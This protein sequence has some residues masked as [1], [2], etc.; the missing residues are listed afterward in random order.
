[1]SKDKQ[2][3]A[4]LRYKSPPIPEQ[5]LEL[6]YNLYHKGTEL[7]TIVRIINSRLDRAAL[8]AGVP[9]LSICDLYAIL[10]IGITTGG[11]ATDN[12]KI[13]TL[14]QRSKHLTHELRIA[15]F[16]ALYRGWKSG[17]TITNIIADDKLYPGTDVAK[18]RAI[19]S[20][21]LRIS[22][23]QEK[24]TILLDRFAK[25]IISNLELTEFD[26]EPALVAKLS[27]LPADVLERLEVILSDFKEGSNI[28]I[29]H[30]DVIVAAMA[31]Q[32]C[33]GN[34]ADKDISEEITQRE[35]TILE[36]R[37]KGIIVTDQDHTFKN[38]SSVLDSER[39]VFDLL[40]TSEAEAEFLDE[41]IEDNFAEEEEQKKTD[42]SEV[43]THEEKQEKIRDIFS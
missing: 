14:S 2:R 40:V 23:Q 26:G 25:E 33:E 16:G 20:L 34:S 15:D 39:E 38:N 22:E 42:A 10:Q 5:T 36:S 12:K 28:V 30:E 9:T 17:D 3:T 18:Q 7:V 43:I 32:P 1:M 29:E 35:K 13:V 4:I 41:H 24:H 27:S 31:D 8:S 21:S 6:I 19:K 11:V 37:K